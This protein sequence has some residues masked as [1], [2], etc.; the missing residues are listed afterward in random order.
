MNELWGQ[1]SGWGNLTGYIFSTP[2]HNIILIVIVIVI[3]N[4]IPLWPHLF[5]E[6]IQD[7]T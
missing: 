7:E 1:K 6:Y 3:N 4:L 5:L 2:C